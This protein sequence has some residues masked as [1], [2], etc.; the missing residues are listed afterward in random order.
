LDKGR[1]VGQAVLLEESRRGPARAIVGLELDWDEIERLYEK[2]GL[3][4][5]IPAAASRVAVPIY[6][7]ARQVGKATTTTWSPTLKK[8]IALATI[9]RPHDAMGT[10][11][12]KE[13]TVEAARHD[14]TARVVKTPFF[15]PPRK[16]ATPP[17]RA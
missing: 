3:A 15:N 1:F 8:M 9:D 10:A 17:F 5:Q 12:R 14:V 4:P 7:E 13:M 6:K 2:V 11:L 16:M